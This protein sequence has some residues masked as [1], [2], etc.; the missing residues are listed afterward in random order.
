MLLDNALRNGC[1]TSTMYERIVKLKEVCSNREEFKKDKFD[2]FWVIASQKED[3]FDH[4][5][6]LVNFY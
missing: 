6:I 4:V 5:F 3:V 2:A 1:L